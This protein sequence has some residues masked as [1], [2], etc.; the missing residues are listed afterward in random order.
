[1]AADADGSHGALLR[2]YGD[3]TRAIDL[4]DFDSADGIIALATESERR[5]VVNL[6]AQSDR[7]LAAWITETGILALAAESGVKVG[8][9]ARHSTTARTR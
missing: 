3:F 1:M 4:S 6:P 2:F 7:P 5:V 9:L 8:V